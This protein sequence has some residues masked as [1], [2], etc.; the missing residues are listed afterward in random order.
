MSGGAPG[1]IEADVVVLG[2]GPAG[3]VAALNLAPFR[4][5]LV[6]E[7][8]GL[9]PART[10]ESLPGAARRLLADMGLWEGFLADEPLPCGL[11]RSRWG[12]AQAV[13]AD[14]LSDPDGP[15]WHLDRARFDARLRATAVARGAALLCPA[16]PRTIARRDAL[17]CLDVAHAGRRLPIRAAFLIDAR[18]R[19]ARPHP[20]LA[21]RR[22][23]DDRLVCG[24][25]EA[26]AAAAGGGSAPSLIEAEAEGWW[27]GAH[28]PG[29]RRLLAF[30]TDADLPA[31]V[32]LR[33]A[34]ALLER[35]RS[36]PALAPLAAEM[37]VGAATGICAAH[38]ARSE[39]SSGPGWIA[40]GD[41]AFAMDPLSS[42]GLFNALY[43]G[44]AAAE[45][46]E[47]TFQGDASA[48][49]TY[50]RA[51]HDVWQAYRANRSAWYGLE[52]RWAQ[53]PFWQRRHGSEN[54]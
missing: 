51:L 31:A 46:A 49:A 32:S 17:W 3:S 16:E 52:R 11:R 28:L 18:G 26:P 39:R 48:H 38:T 34:D 5:V 36:R 44:L 35:A 40:A 6:I 12:G 14:A 27:Y 2:A 9:P 33:S 7:R 37:V 25:I 19:A 42:Q 53:A 30:Y 43:S 24:W 23:V 4:R 1:A 45:A 54:A 41:A 29:G 22:P 21:A 13:E 15:G 47:R 8:R 10:G 20:A 50:A